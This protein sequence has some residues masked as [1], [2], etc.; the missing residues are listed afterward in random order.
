MARSRVTALQE[1]LQKGEQQKV[2]KR[3]GW[4]LYDSHKFTTGETTISMF[5]VPVGV[6]GNGYT[7]AKTLRETNGRASNT[8]P[9]GQMLEAHTLMAYLFDGVAMN[10]AQ[11]LAWMKWQRDGLFHVK[12]TGGDDL[13]Q[14]PIDHIMGTQNNF[15]HVPT[16]A[17]DNVFP[18]QLIAPI[19]YYKLNE[20]IKFAALSQ[21]E[22]TLENTVAIPAALN[23]KEVKFRFVGILKRLGS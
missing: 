17:G 12:F 22:I 6:P 8:I 4:S 5:S 11:L 21:Y 15:I 9:Q 2:G 13:V 19:G 1:Q 10:N 20:K 16:T 18:Q 23:G 14:E 7:V 3:F